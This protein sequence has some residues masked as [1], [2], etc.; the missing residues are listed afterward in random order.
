VAVLGL[1]LA[2]G[3]GDGDPRPP[4]DAAAGAGGEESGA[5]GSPSAGGD[6]D[7]SSGYA[8]GD[9]NTGADT[10]SG[11]E[12]TAQ[13][14]FCGDGVISDDEQCERRDG[15]AVDEIC[16]R[17]Q[18][19]PGPEQIPSSQELI[20]R[21]LQA[22]DIDYATSLMYRV[23]ALFQAPEL[24]E[25]YDG[26]GSTGEDTYLFFELARVRADL[27]AAI[28]SA[29]APYLVRP[30]DP[31]SIFSAS[32][33]AL[34]LSRASAA[35]VDD[36]P[37]AVAC[38]KNAKNVADWRP[39]ESQNFVVW[40]CGG[41][42]DGTDPF[43][44]SREATAKTAEYLLTLMAPKL[45]PLVEDD[46]PDLPKPSRIDIYLL[47]LNEC[48]KRNGD[49]IPVPGDALAA[50]VPATPCGH[51]LGGGPLISSA[52]LM[53]RAGLAPA[54][55]DPAEP[56]P[57]RALLAHE[58]F[59]AFSFGLNLEAQ[60][61]SCTPRTGALLGP[62]EQ[63]SWLTE[64]SAEWASFAFVPEDYPARRVL[65]FERYQRLRDPRFYGLHAVS[66]VLPYEAWLYP[67][68]VQEEKSGDA[69]ALFDFWTKS[70]SARDVTAL[71][72]RLDSLLPFEEHFRDFAVR[73]FNLDQPGTPIPYFH[74]NWDEALPLDLGPLIVDPLVNVPVGVKLALPLKLAPL[75]AEVFAVS[76]SE[77]VQHVELQAAGAAVGGLSIDALVKVGEEWRRERLR[78]P[79]Y[80]FC[81]MDE[82]NEISEMYLI[83]SN[84]DHRREGTFDGSLEIETSAA[85]PGGWSGIMRLKQTF[86]EHTEKSDDFSSEITDRHNVETQE[87]AVT[88]SEPYT[89][90]NTGEKVERASVI[91]RGYTSMA[92]ETATTSG[93]CDGSYLAYE[94]GSGSYPTYFYFTPAGQGSYSWSATELGEGF[95]ADAV[96]T[97]NTCEG[98]QSYTQSHPHPEMV[99]YLSL[100]AGLAVLQDQESDPGHFAGTAKPIHQEAPLS[101]GSNTLEV[102]VEWDLHRTLQR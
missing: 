39:Y 60:G 9:G 8:G 32:G 66:H 75:A 88:G 2:L 20:E 29:V 70:A 85:C 61:G 62:R 74:N 83:V 64:A 56:E 95:Q 94:T 10:S 44:A 69:Q 31:T 93:Q 19:E 18:C 72:G 50:A 3:C 28:E 86:D 30:S 36:E 100:A 17:C 54:V 27:P 4:G 23:W 78:G 92:S 15:C 89:D 63:Q 57:A 25:A 43:A 16:N 96:T 26:S 73:N 34:A 7:G 21:A 99:A 55:F 98:S 1:A 53:L 13:Q 52:Y 38:P 58:L 22:G 35:D 59:H 68:F 14:P 48:R 101:G 71:D 79:R 82:G 67:L 47:D 84:F 90:P 80:E 76:L 49:C 81:R 11:G 97:S 65:L 5:G 102:T 42:V 91:F 33:G 40:S 45:G 41:G 87:W 51:K 37:A 46:F 77:G 6:G 12:P 24:P